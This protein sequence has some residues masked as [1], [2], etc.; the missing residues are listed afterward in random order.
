MTR[1][2]PR[3]PAVRPRRSLCPVSCTLDAIGDRWSL[4]VVRDLMRGKRRYAE[5]LESSEGIPTNILADRLKR[6]Q[7]SGI[8]TSQRYS[9]HPVRLEYHL[10]PK[11]EDLRPMMR[12]MVEWGVRHAGARMPPPLL[13]RE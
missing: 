3:R 13:P 10:T 11:G 1:T 9:S 4:L 12:A 7:A 8:V 5:F 2:V 6:L